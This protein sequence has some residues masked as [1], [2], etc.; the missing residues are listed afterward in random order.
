M[1]SCVSVAG[2]AMIVAAAGKGAVQMDEYR[3]W[4]AAPVAESVFRVQET[5]TYY[6][7]E[8]TTGRERKDITLLRYDPFSDPANPRATEFMYFRLDEFLKTCG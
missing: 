7:L 4:F 5:E 1:L 3:E 2:A 6:Q 8:I